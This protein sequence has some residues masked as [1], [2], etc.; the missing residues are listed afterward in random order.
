VVVA[1]VHRRCPFT[2]EV[3]GA[4]G[5]T[6]YRAFMAQTKGVEVGKSFDP[7][8]FYEV[9]PEVWNEEGYFPV[10]LVTPGA[11]AQKTPVT[12]VPPEAQRRSTPTAVS[13]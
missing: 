12:E 1:L 7:E 6:L 10:G 11:R 13:D 5:G 2:G 4:A 8:Q 9:L 3:I